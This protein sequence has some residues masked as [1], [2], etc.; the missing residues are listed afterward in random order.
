MCVF[1]CTQAPQQVANLHGKF[2]KNTIWEKPFVF[3]NGKSINIRE[4]LWQACSVALRL[5]LLHWLDGVNVNGE[6]KWCCCCK[7]V[8]PSS[9]SLWPGPYGD[10]KSGTGRCWGET[11]AETNW[12][13]V[14]DAQM[15]TNT[16]PNTHRAWHMVALTPIVHSFLHQDYRPQL[17]NMSGAELEYE[18][19]QRRPFPTHVLKDKATDGSS[20]GSAG[21]PNWRKFT[22][23]ALLSNEGGI[24]PPTQL[25]F[26]AETSGG[27]VQ[28][29]PTLRVALIRNPLSWMLSTKHKSYDLTCPGMK[30]NG[31]KV[32]RRIDQKRFTN[33]FFL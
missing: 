25:R 22:A 6:R 8:T 27:I 5:T 3:A 7:D 21:H 16:E 4:T 11:F 13:C 17:A 28:E 14:E 29:I 20:G 1:K 15:Q 12:Q 19:G 30:G 26:G 32:C 23:A 24:L 2:L 31:N 33:S 9:I 10:A 18:D